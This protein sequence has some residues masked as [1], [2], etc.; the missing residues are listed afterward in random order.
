MLTGQEDVA[1]DRDATDRLAMGLRTIGSAEAAGGRAVAGAT[2]GSGNGIP[3][4]LVKYAPSSSRLPPATAPLTFAMISAGPSFA[5][6]MGLARGSRC[7]P[8]TVAPMAMAAARSGCWRGS[9]WFILRLI[10]ILKDGT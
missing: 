10:A 4:L 7:P 9:G 3:S 6:Y 1:R 2:H 5:L 8:C